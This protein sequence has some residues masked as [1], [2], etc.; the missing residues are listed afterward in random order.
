MRAF[1][2]VD[3]DS[4]TVLSV[5]LVRRLTSLLRQRGYEVRQVELCRG[6]AAPCRGCL[7]CLTKHPG[8]CVSS[9]TVAD[10]VQ[11]LRGERHDAITITV[12]PVAFG[13]PSSTIKNAMDRGAESPRLQVVIGYG[14]DIVAEE[15]STFIDITDKHC[16]AAD[17]VHP[18]MVREAM[19]FVTRTPED[20]A[21]ICDVLEERL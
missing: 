15:A 17:I 12:T 13:H 7:L 16:G 14:E 3:R 4:A 20:S 1:V 2:I 9:D 19:A 6:E 21:K 18:G 8:R 5:D 10:L 11:E